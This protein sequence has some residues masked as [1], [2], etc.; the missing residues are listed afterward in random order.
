MPS[1]T[2]RLQSKVW[3]NFHAYVGKVGWGLDVKLS[4]FSFYAGMVIAWITI[5]KPVAWLKSNWIHK[6]FLT[7][8][9][10]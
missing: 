10:V 8:K 5:D 2:G 7:A 3:K 6:G 9:L 1:W 4:I